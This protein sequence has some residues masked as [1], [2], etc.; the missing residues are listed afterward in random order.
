MRKKGGRGNGF[1]ETF[2]IDESI[3][4]AAARGISKQLLSL[5]EANAERDILRRS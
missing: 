2:L 5:L 1:E 4:N 3:E